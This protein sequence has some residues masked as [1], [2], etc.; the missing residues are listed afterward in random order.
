M[1]FSVST[2]A[3][4]AKSATGTNCLTDYIGILGAV[5]RATAQKQPNGIDP[6][7]VG[8]RKLC[9]RNLNFKNDELAA[10]EVCC[11]Y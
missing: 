11:K 10:A 1:F 2:D 4:K 9:G 6:A 8:D 3:A 5:D 7:D